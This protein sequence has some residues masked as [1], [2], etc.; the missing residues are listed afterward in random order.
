[1]V[2][3]QKENVFTVLIFSKK[4]VK[5]EP[6]Y[7]EQEVSQPVSFNITFSGL[8]KLVLL[9]E[10]KN[11]LNEIEL[12]PHYMDRYNIVLHSREIQ[13]NPGFGT[14]TI[15]G[16]LDSTIIVHTHRRV[17]FLPAKVDYYELGTYSN[18]NWDFSPAPHVVIYNENTPT[19]L[20]WNVDTSNDQM[21][22]GNGIE[23]A[24]NVHT[25]ISVFIKA[26]P[27]LGRPPML[28]LVADVDTEAGFD[29]FHVGYKAENNSDITLALFSGAGSLNLE[30]S[31]WEM[32]DTTEIFFT[33]I[34][35]PAMTAKGVNITNLMVVG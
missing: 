1:M 7:S 19:E 6:A 11:I 10:N 29:F 2:I 8:T 27:D 13:A 33:F 16:Y 9:D 23:Y 24:N 17:R 18:F 5:S 28:S 14:F 22:I 35:D 32:G 34:S 4:I 25:Q 21:V 15:Q 31:L 12:A 20:G 3:K 26:N 30:E